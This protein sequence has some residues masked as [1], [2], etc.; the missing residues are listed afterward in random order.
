SYSC[1]SKKDNAN[2]DT[3]TITTTTPAT[4]AP[5]EISGDDE[6]RRGV[7]D[8]TKDFPGVDATVQDGVI[9]LN[10]TIEKDRY[11][12]LKQSLDALRPKQV[13]NNLKYK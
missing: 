5:V 8:A 7:T 13:V 2:T 10:G 6:L 12:T 9:T 1:K 3:T 11:M 4:T